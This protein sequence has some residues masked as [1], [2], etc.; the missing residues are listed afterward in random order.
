MD[1]NQ[2]CPM[3]GVPTHLEPVYR[4]NKVYTIFFYRRFISEGPA[5]L[6]DADSHDKLLN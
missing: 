4:I 5:A 3:A 2:A 6:Q 1:V